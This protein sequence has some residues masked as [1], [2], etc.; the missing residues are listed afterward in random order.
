MGGESF[1][2]V[3]DLRVVGERS[4]LGGIWGH[5]VL[6]EREIIFGCTLACILPTP[7]A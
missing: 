2:L 1:N 6:G 7:E 5:H 3:A 4:V